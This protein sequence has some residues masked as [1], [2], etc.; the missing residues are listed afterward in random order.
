MART[1][2]IVSKETL[3]LQAY[4]EQQ[5]PGT[6]L[7]YY[8]ISHDTGVELDTKGK[9]YLRTALHRAKKEYTTIHNQGIVLADKNNAMDIVTHRLDKIDKAVKRGEKTHKNIQAQFFD[10]L[11]LEKQKEILYIGA[12][13]GAIRVAADNGKIM[14]SNNSG[15]K[16]INSSLN[17]QIPKL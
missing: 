9:T 6:E 17:I 2:A 8:K 16:Q 15:K 4:I 5:K 10:S 14:Y 1:I 3:K 7:S 12:V 13:F 11:P